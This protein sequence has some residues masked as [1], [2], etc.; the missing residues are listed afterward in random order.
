[1]VAMEH[2]AVVYGA[3]K[4]RRHAAARGEHELDALDAAGIVEADVVVDD[5]V[6]PLAGHDHV[7]VAVKP[8]LAGFAGVVRHHRRDAGNQR[9]L[10]LLA[11]ERPT[12]AAAFDDHVLEVATDRGGREVLHF[13]RVLCRAVYE[14]AAVL[15]RERHRD[16]PF[17]VELVLPA[18]TGTAASPVL[19]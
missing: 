13:T 15:A 12:H 10:A 6:V 14:E 5:E 2:C 7:V 3:G 1:V 4:I 17:E 19:R 16:L 8:E 11:A 9:R 18:D